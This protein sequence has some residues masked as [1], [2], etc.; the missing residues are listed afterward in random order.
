MKNYDISGHAWTI[1]KSNGI[2]RRRVDSDSVID[3]K[4]PYNNGVSNLSEQFNFINSSEITLTLI[5]KSKSQSHINESNETTSK[6]SFIDQDQCILNGDKAEEEKETPNVLSIIENYEEIQLTKVNSTQNFKAAVSLVNTGTNN[7]MLDELNSDKFEKNSLEQKSDF[8]TSN[9]GLND[10]SEITIEPCSSSQKSKISSPSSDESTAKK[11]PRTQLRLSQAQ[12]LLKKKSAVSPSVALFKT[13]ARKDTGFGSERFSVRSD[14]PSVKQ[15][16]NNYSQQENS[17][18][19][20]DDS[21]NVPVPVPSDS[22]FQGFNEVGISCSR[23]Y[24]KSKVKPHYVIGFPNLPMENRCWANATFQVLFALP[25]I[26]NIHNLQDSSK[27][28]KLL[29]NLIS[30]QTIWRT[31][32]PRNYNYDNCFK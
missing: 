18:F 12:D 26:S 1:E 23:F 30:I 11:L 2:K 20:E 14:T 29:N 32:S 8:L 6:T 15:N 22:D 21:D 13:S 16:F 5:P 27:R 7:S 17:P 25:P 9:S 4:K 28:S 24:S 3:K 10:L 31:G 19:F